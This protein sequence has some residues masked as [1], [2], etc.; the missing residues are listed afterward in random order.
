ML[1]LW[2]NNVPMSVE[3]LMSPD[4]RLGQARARS[5]EVTAMPEPGSVLLEQWTV[6]VLHSALS[7][8]TLMSSLAL[9]Q[10]FRSYLHFSQVSV[11]THPVLMCVTRV[12]GDMKLV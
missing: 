3:V 1:L 10:A 11:R 12:G 7:S 5:L 4:C 6:A 2:Q 8:G 9:L